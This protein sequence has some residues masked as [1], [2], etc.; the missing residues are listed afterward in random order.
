[1]TI[2][3]LETS[4]AVCSVGLFSEGRPPVERS[5]QESHIH[6][7]KLL[8]LVRDVL[9]EGGT[10]LSRLAAIAISIGPGSFTGL[11]IGLSTAKGL[12][13]ALDRPL[14]AVPTFDAIA[15]A[16]RQKSPAFASLM[17][18]IDA[19]KDEWYM[20]SYDVRGESLSPSLPVQI[21]TLDAVARIVRETKSLLVLTDR[22]GL[23]KSS[24][25]NAAM[26]EDVYSCCRGDVV[27]SL[28]RASVGA[29]QFAEASSLEP[30]YLKDFVIRT[31]QSGV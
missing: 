17:V 13:F 2:L 19:K 9:H 22:A 28:A 4:T 10:G 6:S 1:M 16:R 5:L 14:V 31:Q 27:A 15:E 23:L 29:R 3:G 8:S 25:D 12:S 7:E 11:R 26:I 30:M 18:V 20:A 21:S 24:L